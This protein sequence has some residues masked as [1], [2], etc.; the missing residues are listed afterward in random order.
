MSLSG[1]N[2]SDNNF[3]FSLAVDISPCTLG[4]S[5]DADLPAEKRLPRCL[6]HRYQEMGTLGRP[7]FDPKGNIT[8]EPPW[9][10]LKLI[11]TMFIKLVSL[12]STM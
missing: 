1:S 2:F 9:W 3:S 10:F 6:V 8:L 11:S 7:V 4:N 5:T 12:Q